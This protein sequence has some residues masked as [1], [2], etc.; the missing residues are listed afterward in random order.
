MLIIIFARLNTQGEKLPHASTTTGYYHC[1]PTTR[2]EHIKYHRLRLCES[3]RH[4][5]RV[6]KLIHTGLYISTPTIRCWN[7]NMPMNLPA[8][9]HI[10]FHHNYTIRWDPFMGSIIYKS[11]GFPT[12]ETIN[13][14][15][16]G[17]VRQLDSCTHN[18]STYVALDEIH[19]DSYISSL[20]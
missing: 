12:I 19:H 5:P 13:R 9:R 8:P 20:S 15:P 17:R 4:A 2:G 7:Y 18:T 11:I 6:L 16:S 3:Q 10:M 1:R 14:L